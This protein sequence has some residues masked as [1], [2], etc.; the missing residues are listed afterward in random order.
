MTNSQTELKKSGAISSLAAWAM[1]FGCAVG[2]G[3]FVMPGT[4]FLP[5]AGPAGTALGVLIGALVMLIGVVA[6]TYSSIF[7]AT[8]IMLW[9]Y[10]GKRPEFE[11]EE[12]KSAD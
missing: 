9:W 5:I 1:A 10:R 2:W 4:T 6:G 8:P 12:R 7:I 3:S 11:A